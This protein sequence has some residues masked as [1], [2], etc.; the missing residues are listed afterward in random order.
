MDIAK[1]KVADLDGNPVIVSGVV[2][3]R[4]VNSKRAALDVTNATQYVHIQAQTILK[5]V[6]SRYPYESAADG[7]P[8]LKTETS[9][10]GRQLKS[11]LQQRA[12]VAG[13]EIITFELADLS[14]APEI[15]QM[16]LVRQQAKAMVDARKTIVKGAV[17]IVSEAL[18]ELRTNGLTLEKDEVSKLTTN[19][20][21]VIC[22]ESGATPTIA[23]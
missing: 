7:R 14:Y 4:I 13:V 20:L 18:E 6:V 22:G 9:D 17:G 12:L 15:A 10:I 5:Q 16:M 11:L 2:S 23:L 21:T 3:Y 1:Q 8:S 19:L